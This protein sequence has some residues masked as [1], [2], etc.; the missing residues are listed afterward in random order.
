MAGTIGGVSGAVLLTQ[1]PG[2]T[3][4]PF[5]FVYLMVMGLVILL[6]CLRDGEERH[7]LH[8]ASSFHSAGSAD[9]SMRSAA[10]DGDPSSRQA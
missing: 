5:V 2:K 6:R 3:I 1:I 8:Q 7:G 9:F 4:R 10:V